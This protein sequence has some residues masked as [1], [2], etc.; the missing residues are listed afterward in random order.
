MIGGYFNDIINSIEKL[1]GGPMKP[2]RSSKI[3]NYIISAT[4]FI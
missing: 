1:G 2:S 4:L 3:W